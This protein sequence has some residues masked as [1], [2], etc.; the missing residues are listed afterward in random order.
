MNVVIWRKSISNIYISALSICRSTALWSATMSLWGLIL[1]ENLGFYFERQ[2]HQITNPLTIRVY[3]GSNFSFLLL[4]LLSDFGFVFKSQTPIKFPSHTFNDNNRKRDILLKLF[5]IVKEELVVCIL[6]SI[7][8]S[9]LFLPN[10]NRIGDLHL[11]CRSAYSLIRIFNVWIKLLL[12]LLYFIL[13]FS[14]FNS[15]SSTNIWLLAFKSSA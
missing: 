9:F 1:S 13:D 3:I 15:L 5:N 6:F 11:V 4:Y 10:L 8:L 14:P 2:S 12:W 7:N